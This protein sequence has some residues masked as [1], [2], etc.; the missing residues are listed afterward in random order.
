M[1]YISSDHIFPISSEPV[2][3]VVIVV[4]NDGLIMDLLDSSEIPENS[5]IE[6]HKGCIVPGF[7]NTH[8]HLELSHLKGHISENKGMTGFIA[9]LLGKRPDFPDEEILAGIEKGEQ[10]MIRN[11]IVAVA[12]ICNTRDSF[13]QKAK[14]NLWYHTFIEIFSMDPEKAKDIFEKGKDLSK[15][16]SALKF[17]NSITPHAP[18]T[19][20]PDLLKLIDEEAKQRKSIISIHNQE[21]IGESELFISNSGP[22]FDAFSEMGIKKELMRMTGQNSL[23]STLPH[24]KDASRIL[25]VHNT[26]TN[27]EDILW[28]NSTLR[29]PHSALFWCTCPNA[30]LY[31]ENTLPDYPAFIKNKAS[32]TIGTDSLASNHSLSV[33]DEI[34]TISKYFPEIPLQTLLT[35]A[36]KNGAMFLGRDEFGSI[37]KGKKPGLNLLKG[38]DGFKLTD[39]TVV[40]KLV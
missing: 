20:S 12:D 18:Y 4:G 29:T 30:N 37:E 6:K 34:R 5:Q 8:C 23:R 40:E 1:R 24:L 17:S 11:G 14:G 27:E 9:E 2:Q 3:G 35:W 32:I 36:T 31:I 21:S 28:A 25:L 16:L 38:M 10:E 33:L 22:M 13:L 39:H 7:I 19:M 26:Y 15:Q